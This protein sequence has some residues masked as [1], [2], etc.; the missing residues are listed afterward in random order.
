MSFVFLFSLNANAQNASVLNKKQKPLVK[1]QIELRSDVS[2]AKSMEP[3][4]Y[5]DFDAGIPAEWSQITVGAGFVSAYGMA[6]HWDNTGAQN[7]WLISPAI[8][9]PRGGLILEF[10]EYQNYASYAGAHNVAVATQADM[11][12]AVVVYNTVGA[13]GYND[14]NV[15]LDEFDNKTVYIG[16]QYLGNYSDHW[17]IDEFALLAA[18]NVLTFEMTGET[19]AAELDFANSTITTHMPYGADL[20]AVASTFTISAGATSSPASGEAMDLSGESGIINVTAGNGMGAELWYIDVVIANPPLVSFD[21][22]AASN[23]ALS[24]DIT[25]VIDVDAL[26]VEAEVPYATVVTALSPTIV[27]GPGV[28]VTPST[29]FDA[30]HDYTTPVEFELDGTE[31]IDWTATVTEAEAF[32]TGFGFTGI[33]DTYGDAHDIDGVI[34]Q[35]A[36][37]IVL[38]VPYDAAI[39]AI[40]PVVEFTDGAIIT[41]AIGAQSFVADVD[42]TLSGGTVDKTYTVSV[43]FIDA[44]VET[45]LVSIS[46]ENMAID[47]DGETLEI[48]RDNYAQEIEMQILPDSAL[49]ALHPVFSVS[50][51]ATISYGA[52]TAFATG[53][54]VDFTNAVVFTIT[55]QD[56]VN[57]SEWLV[58]VTNQDSLT[59]NDILDA[60]VKVADA[61]IL[62]AGGDSIQIDVDAKRI[63]AYVVDTTDLSA[64]DV[65]FE[66]SPFATLILPTTP[67]WTAVVMADVVSQSNDTAEWTIEVLV[68]DT[69]KPVATATAISITNFG[70]SVFVYTNETPGYVGILLAGESTDLFFTDE[71]D[72]DDDEE[73][74]F[75]GVEV[76]AGDTGAYIFTEGLEAGNYAVYACDSSENISDSIVVVIEIDTAIVEIASLREFRDG[77]PTIIYDIAAEVVMTHHNYYKNKKWLTD[78]TAGLEVYDPDAVIA[79]TL[80]NGDVA[81]NAGDAFMHLQGMQNVYK[82]LLSLVPYVAPDS[83]WSTG[84]E[85]IPIVITL[86]Q[87]AYDEELEEYKG[88]DEFEGQLVTIEN[89][90]FP[91][92]DGDT[93][94]K[95]GKNYTIENY[96]SATFR[97]EFYDADYIDSVIPEGPI[98]L[99]ALVRSY[100]GT[101]QLSARTLADFVAIEVPV[102]YAEVEEVDFESILVGEDDDI[103]LRIGN[104]GADGLEISKIYLEGHN[105]FVLDGAFVDVTLANNEFVDVGIWFVPVSYGA[106]E[107]TLFVEYGDEVLE[108]PV[109]GEGVSDPLFDIPYFTDFE[110][111]WETGLWPPEGWTTDG[112]LYW[113]NSAQAYDGKIAA[114]MKW[115]IGTF[116]PPA[117]DLTD[118]LAP[119]VQFK[120]G[121]IFPGNSYKYLAASTNK[122]D[123]DILEV[124]VAPDILAGPHGD[125]IIPLD[126]YIG[127]KVYL[128]FYYENESAFNNYYFIDAFEVKEFATTT[129]FNASADLIDFGPVEVADTAT[130]ELTIANIG[131][132]YFTIDTIYMVTA[133]TSFLFSNEVVYPFTTRDGDATVEVSLVPDTS[134]IHE[135]EIVVIYTDPVTGKDTAYVA[136]S[137]IGYQV[138][139]ADA[140]EAIEGENVADFAPAWFHFTMPEDGILHITSCGDQEVD[141]DL[142]VYTD[143]DGTLVA[144]NDDI[145]SEYDGTNLCPNGYNYASDVS[146]PATKDV[147]YKISWVDKW[148]ADGFTFVVETYPL[149]THPSIVEV[150]SDET[151]PR[152]TIDWDGIPLALGQAEPTYVLYRNGV[153]LVEGLTSSMHVDLGL[154]FDTEYC[155]KVAQVSADG[156]MSDFSSN[157]CVTTLVAGIVGDVCENAIEIDLPVVSLVDSTIN[158]NNDYAGPSAC[159]DHYLEGNDVVYAFTVEQGG[160]LTGSIEGEYA[161]MHVIN[162]CP[163]VDFEDV[164]CVAFANEDNSGIHGFNRTR[165]AAGTYYVIV[166][167]WSTTEPFG[168]TYTMNL[169]FEVRTYELT[170][171]DI[172]GEKEVS[173]YDGEFVTTSGIVTSTY[174]SG[175]YLQDGDGAWNG[176]QVYD[177]DNTVARGDS[178]TITG[179]CLEY[180]G[181]TNIEE[182]TTFVNN[183]SDNVIPTAAVVAVGDV[184]EAYESVLTSVKYVL[185]VEA[186]DNGTFV[187][188][189]N[190][191]LL[192]ISKNIFAYETPQVR[193]TYDITGIVSYSD[194]E[195]N[196]QPR[197]IA[198]VVD[199]L[200][201]VEDINAANAFGVYPNPSNGKFTV[202][203]NSVKAQDLRIELVSI[204]GEVIYSNTHQNVTKFNSEIDV[205]EY[206]KGIY[207]L[208]VNN[209]ETVKIEKVVIQ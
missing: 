70:D 191:D 179:T 106:K 54:A 112:F 61:N 43:V 102:L 143:C 64:I 73:Y 120:H 8:V 135:A 177:V 136:V 39:T 145:D 45:E 193:H 130:A 48:Y 141:T 154:E 168:I 109:T 208:R 63:L 53:D 5:E 151:F 118:A 33:E 194:G 78:G 131:T 183:S 25:G 202:V 47:N 110:E 27:Y 75:R 72:L 46:V 178:I 76:A 20:S 155:Y 74:F 12:D 80:D 121:E 142:H 181:V 173:S 90:S 52:K 166:S 116:M 99:T 6:I 204:S 88:L 111:I 50:E 11:S 59:G 107:A 184:D 172:Q 200:V 26:T 57:T 15:Y 160:Y 132:S 85:I 65:T 49:T 98:N 16:F 36:K 101:P 161:G 2:K 196:L 205:T 96:T 129:T 100:Y 189:E 113:N 29:F 86:D 138:S 94:F 192:T 174:S 38:T 165:I 82:G 114:Y 119:V 3:Y 105:D 1:Q 127:G 147:D 9:V 126:D 56:G 206:A 190:S 176:I 83:A 124:L 93:I 201:S 163:G 122:V 164:S 79:D 51:Y 199:L 180:N 134:G 167:S 91:I 133:D 187:V 14:I 171:F 19:E 77:Y 62:V 169:S 185:C 198:D 188:A 144:E 37:T 24:V 152:I 197:D 186:L 175:Y 97:S 28:M 137:G 157:I 13:N 68:E 207:Y 159:G 170:I 92:A 148:T 7:D 21:F 87:L 104:I 35:D 71:D 89:V 162:S 195:F 140:A 69:L 58:T 4:F 108:I 128:K 153:V 32:I 103:T 209:G 115:G 55:S 18:T 41:P 31:S 139:C 81:Y 150:I 156:V 149:P 182:I 40:T 10:T 203:V 146:F 117:F 95:G 34:D 42:Y 123:W 84:N 23:A 30:A 125:I 66:I 67:D 44:I 17:G 60:S 22:E 158:F